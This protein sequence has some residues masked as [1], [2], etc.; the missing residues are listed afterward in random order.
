MS[1][2]QSD[3]ADKQQADRRNHFYR[4]MEKFDYH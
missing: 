3:M 4:G 2:L 1:K